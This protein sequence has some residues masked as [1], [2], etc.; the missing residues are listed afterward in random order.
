MSEAR[1]G[2][3]VARGVV[4]VTHDPDDIGE[5]FWVVVL[6]FE[7]CFT[8]VRMGEVVQDPGARAER[9]GRNGWTP[10]GDRW[11]T[12]LDRVAYETAVEE[13][14]ERIASGTV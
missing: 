13:I 8:A 7:G 6:T 1:F 2:S 12:S 11:R 14:R 10:V 9:G 3:L 5:G 4:A